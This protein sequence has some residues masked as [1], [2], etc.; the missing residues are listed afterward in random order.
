M[1]EFEIKKTNDGGWILSF[2]GKFVSKFET[3]A[4]AEEK[5]AEIKLLIIAGGSRGISVRP[6]RSNRRL[7]K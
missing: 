2:D 4:E 5:M 1:A 3:M 6:G 7:R